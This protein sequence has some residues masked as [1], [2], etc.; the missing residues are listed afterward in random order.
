MTQKQIKTLRYK[1]HMT[2]IEFAEHLE[3]SLHTVRS[4]EQGKYKPNERTEY[5]LKQIAKELI[6]PSTMCKGRNCT[7]V[8]GGFRE[9]HSVECQKDHEDSCNGN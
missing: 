1:L 6:S 4:W 3:V 8:G 7:V 2:Q 5:R 9:D